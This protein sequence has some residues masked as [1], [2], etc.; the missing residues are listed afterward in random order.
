M[1]LSAGTRLGPYDILALIGA[2]GMGEVYRAR[3]TKLQREVAIKVLPEAFAADADRVVRF[4]REA[5]LLASLNHPGIAHIYGVEERALVMELVPGSTLAARIA[6]GPIPLEEALPIAAQIAEAVEYAHDHNVVHRDLKP[7]NIKVTPDGTVKVLDFGLA[8][9]L[10]DEPDAIDPVNSPTLTMTATRGGVL[11]GTAAYMSPEQAKGKPV[12]RRA[13]IWAFGVVLYEMLTGKSLHHGE[14][15]AET[16]A[17]VLLKDAKLDALPHNTPPAIRN[18]LKRCLEKDPRQRLQ[19]IGEARILLRNPA[20]Q[21]EQAAPLPVAPQRRPVV[22][23][24][25]AVLL[26]V[27]LGIVVALWAPWREPP[28]AEVVR[29]QVPPPENVSY[30]VATPPVLSPDGRRLAFVASPRG[31]QLGQ[32]WVRSLDTLEAHALPGTE[33]AGLVLFW[34][35]DSRSLA[36]GD[37]TTQSDPQRS[38]TLALKRVEVSGGPPQTLCQTGNSVPTGSWSREGVIA[39]SHGGIFR[40]P[41][42]GGDCAALTK[43]DNARG[44]IV[45]RFPSFLPDGRHFVYLRV[46]SRPENQ[47]IYVGSLDVRPEQQS[48]KRLMPAESGALYAPSPDSKAG[49]LLFIRDGTLMAQAFDADRLELQGEAVPVAEHVGAFNSAVGAFFSSS[50]T[51]A[52]AYRTG[53]GAVGGNLRLTWFDRQGKVLGT[54]GDEG[55]HNTPSMSPDGTQVAFTRRESGG[56]GNPDVW[57]LDVVRGI[58]T[59]FTFHPAADVAPV[60]SPDGSHIAFASERDGPLNLYQ[61]VSNNAGNEEV[62]FQSAEPK[63]PTD[64]SH[65]GRFL[66]FTDT[67]PKTGP[68]IWV[69]PMIGERKPVPYLKTEFN[70]TEARFSPDDRFVAYQS[71]L[72]GTNEIYVQTFP[73]PAGGRWTIGTGNDPRWSRNGKELFYLTGGSGRLMA[74]PVTLKPAFHAGLPKELFT[75]PPG[76]N[77]YDVT[78]DGQKLIRFAFGTDPATSGAPPSPIT[79]VL[80]WTAGLR[81]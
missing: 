21:Q 37:L 57:L 65:D 31:G 42:A 54:V 49:H 53:V 52:L 72:S 63:T 71:N 19:A 23:M 50:V 38:G 78:A 73:D 20:A 80:N 56:A 69:L 47:G 11:L 13:D 62:L 18:L 75:F 24:A 7:A 8:K 32:V 60:W 34:S 44:E 22:W 6:A 58:S 76:P 14:T 27:A 64:W 46:S 17:A 35:P 66:L 16:L 67:D 45:H 25:F 79:V 40:V 74:V 39:F 1:A 29:F 51:G 59:R 15:V 70:E 10:A 43:P 12:D 77:S 9:A 2:G 4:T 61:K 30:S 48:S 3:D 81:K 33:N 5:L 36:Y 55:Q 41:A 28:A 26:A 68:D